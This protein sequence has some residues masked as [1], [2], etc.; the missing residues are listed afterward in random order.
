MMAPM[1]TTR[2]FKYDNDASDDANDDDW[3]SGG[4]RIILSCQSELVRGK[5][6]SL[7]RPPS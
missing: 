5:Q 3:Q 7:V 1:R 4:R 6:I 2:Q